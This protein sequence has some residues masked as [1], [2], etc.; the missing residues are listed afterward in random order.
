MTGRR[1]VYFLL[2]FTAAGLCALCGSIPAAAAALLLLLTPLVCVPLHLAAARRLRV[3]LRVPV[4]LEKDEAGTLAVEFQKSG[5]LPLCLIGCSLSV[6]NRLTGGRQRLFVRTFAPVGRKSAA[7]YDFV[8]AHCG[9][10]LVQTRRVRLYDPFGLIGIPWKDTAEAK[11]TVQ[12]KGF[13]QS[14]L[15]R[16]DAWCPDDSETYS[17]EKPGFD[18]SEVYQLRDYQPG[19]SLRQMH[20][21]L[22]EK[23]DRLVIREPS[24]PVQ[25]SILVLWERAQTESAAQSDAQADVIVTLCR[26]LLEAGA[27]FTLA[28]ND[29]AESRLV[30]QP[31]HDLDELSGILPRLLAAR[32]TLEDESGAERFCRSERAAAFSHIVYLTGAQPER[33]AG[34]E[35]FGRL[36]TLCEA[37]G[38]AQSGAVTFD[39]EHYPEQ[40]MELTV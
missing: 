28:W 2:L 40:L 34:L 32:A 12:P 4:N 26:S 10:L 33:G 25:R 18:L 8:S 13:A 35:R 17:Q 15:V 31:L 3:R 21:K 23:L 6:E 29:T 11:T 16:Q 19:D 36:T 38:A 7:E 27:Q 9:S 20:W 1:I 39:T 5:F 24:L 30:M 22:S 37:D 14:V